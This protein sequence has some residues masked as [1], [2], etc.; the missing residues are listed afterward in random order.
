MPFPQPGFVAD[1]LIA[2]CQ[3]ATQYRHFM[4]QIPVAG[5]KGAAAP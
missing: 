5:K 2:W 3:A 1:R 4:V